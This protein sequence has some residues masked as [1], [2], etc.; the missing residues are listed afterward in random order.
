MVEN[1]HGMR[2]IRVIIHTGLYW[3][4]W[5]TNVWIINHLTVGIWTVLGKLFFYVNLFYMLINWCLIAKRIPE[6]DRDTVKFSLF[7]I[8][9]LVLMELP[10]WI[11]V[12]SHG[13][14]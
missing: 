6:V 9:I 10:T 12:L 13:T 8:L 1:S 14:G 5:W 7:I 2:M 3:P 4:L 11:Y